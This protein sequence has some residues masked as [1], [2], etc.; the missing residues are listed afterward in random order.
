MLFKSTLALSLAFTADAFAV[1]RGANG[2]SA[3]TVDDHLITGF[4]AAVNLD[5]AA[6]TL[7]G[8]KAL[9]TSTTG[10]N[11]TFNLDDLNAHGSK[12]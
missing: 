6:T 12:P 10:N 8:Q 7:V 2:W 3:P 9:L 5:P 1:R 11:S 4:T